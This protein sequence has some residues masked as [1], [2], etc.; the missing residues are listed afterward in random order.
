MFTH[1][2]SGNAKNQQIKI[3][4][5]YRIFQLKKKDIPY[6]PLLKLF[7]EKPK[8]RSSHTKSHPALNLRISFQPNNHKKESTEHCFKFLFICIVYLPESS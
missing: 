5:Y 1:S 8:I 7:E 2:I 6:N 3:R 4:G